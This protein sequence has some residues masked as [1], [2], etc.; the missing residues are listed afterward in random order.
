MSVG[1][2]YLFS[3]DDYYHELAD[4]AGI[5]YQDDNEFQVVLNNIL[6][7]DN[8]HKKYSKKLLSRDFVEIL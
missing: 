8:L 4:K 5:Y 2:P 7:D 1:V 3:D 6:D